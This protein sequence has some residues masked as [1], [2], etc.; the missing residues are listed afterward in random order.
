MV[1]SMLFLSSFPCDDLILGGHF[2][3]SSTPTIET[4]NL[5]KWLATIHQQCQTAYGCKHG[6]K[7]HNYV[8]ENVCFHKGRIEL[9]QLSCLSCIAPLRI[10]SRM[11][12]ACNSNCKNLKVCLS[13]PTGKVWL[14]DHTNL[15]SNSA[16]DVRLSNSSSFHLDAD[17]SPS[18]PKMLAAIRS[19]APFSHFK[20]SLSTSIPMASPCHF[21]CSAVQCWS[22]RSCPEPGKC[23][24]LCTRYKVYP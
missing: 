21:G 22:C 9:K 3:A 16:I 15:C 6:S 23:I 7:Q 24:I 17:L 2:C 19:S 12:Q 8:V 14:E 20:A 4:E 18:K 13:L 5:W 11:T 1:F 10:T